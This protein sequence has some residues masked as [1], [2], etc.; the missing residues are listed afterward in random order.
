MKQLELFE[1]RVEILV[2]LSICSLIFSLNLLIKYNEFSEFSSQKYRF[3]D[4]TLQSSYLKTG[5]K[6]RIYRVLKLKT[7]KFSFYTT[8]RSEF[9]IEIGKKVHLGIV[10]NGIKF[11]DFVKG[12]FYAPSFKIKE[13]NSPPTLKD[14]VINFISSQHE[15]SKMKELYLALYFATPIS[16][17]LR[18]D[19]ARWGIA[20][21][22]AISGFHLGI[23]FGFC[24]AI[25][26]P[27]YRF[28]QNR[29]F[30]YRSAKFDITIAILVLMTGY[31]FV[32]DFTPSFLRSFVMCCVGFLFL[33]RNFEIINF[34]TLFLTIILCISFFPNLLFSLGFYFSSLGVFYIF[35]FLRHY[36][37]KFK[38]WQNAL[39]LNIYVFF[40]MNIPVYY[41][42]DTI[43]FQQISV[44]LLGYIFVVFY[45][46]SIVLHILGFGGIFDRY[47]SEFFQFS[48]P[49]YRTT[50]PALL[51]YAVNLIS[52]LAVRFKILT[53]ML[54]FLGIMPFLLI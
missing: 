54:A 34:L 37:N 32:L 21:I 2:F 7:D 53:I 15:I 23:I 38:L 25:I 3:Y 26:F 31:L 27:I 19:V 49:V 1:K 13:L 50:I 44:V 24:F 35:L 28:F 9:N 45:P 39:L 47:L 48:L 16:K 42:F 20:H 11:L 51:F 6:D 43:T 41:F 36:G 30:P 4:A 14:R 52:L 40:A 33:M 22:I 12:T 17:E 46:L 29:Y 10:T 18:S 5:E 8:T